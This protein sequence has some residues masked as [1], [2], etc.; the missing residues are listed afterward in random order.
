MPRGSTV[1]GKEELATL[2]RGW[3]NRSAQQ[4][5]GDVGT[6][7]G[8][9]WIWI[10]LGARRAHLNADTTRAAVRAYIDHVRIHGADADWHVVANRRGKVNKVLYGPPGADAPAWYCYLTDEYTTPGRT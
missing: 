7:G 6:Y 10:E 1:Q 2:L 9:A 5:I 3:L 4:T 8:R